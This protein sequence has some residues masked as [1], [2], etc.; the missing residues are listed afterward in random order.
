MTDLKPYPE[1]KDCGIEWVGE[2]PKEWD[3]SKIKYLSKINQSKLSD[4]TDDTYEIKYIDIGSV[5]S[6]GSISIETMNFGD[7]PSRARRILNKGDIIISTVRT[8][9]RAI[10]TIEHQENNLICSTG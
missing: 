9:L 10:A 7:A 6:T 3:I 5:D 1:Y 2:I 8:Y 4:K